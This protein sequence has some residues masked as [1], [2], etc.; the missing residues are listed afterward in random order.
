MTPQIGNG[1]YDSWERDKGGHL[2]YGAWLECNDTYPF[3]FWRLA[4]LF[5][6]LHFAFTECIM[7]KYIYT[8]NSLQIIEKPESI[9][10]KFYVQTQ[11]AT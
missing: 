10:W 2:G 1:N 9:G 7:R 5:L 3:S 6:N 11:E 8:P 4:H